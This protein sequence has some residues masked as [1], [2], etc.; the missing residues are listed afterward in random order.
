MENQIKSIREIMENL[1]IAEKSTPGPNGERPCCL[2]L[3]P[4]PQTSNYKP[5]D[6]KC[7]H[8]T[9]AE[10]KR[11]EERRNEELNYRRSQLMS[12]IPTAFQRTERDKLPMP[13]K[14][15]AAL[16]WEFGKSGLLLYGGTGKGKSRVAWKVSEREILNGR[17]FQH[18]NSFILAQYPA[19]L[20]K[21]SEEADSFVKKLVSCDLLLLDDVFKA[22][23][24]ERVEE[25]LFAVVD[26]RG[27]WERP[28]I[29]T[30]NDTS[31]T[32]SGRLSADRGPA[33]VRRLKDYCVTIKFE[34]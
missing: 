12:R 3:K 19:M 8:C 34:Q 15:D 23:P 1:E 27:E 9:A 22:K 11:D 33:L 21:S 5:L 30:L 20:M 14:L 24:T 17:S 25:L 4:V 2:C 16:R 29:V 18:V 26:E 10:E 32:L 6:V 7:E 13:D 28:C 31:D